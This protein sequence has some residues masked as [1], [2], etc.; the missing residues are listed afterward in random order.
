MH[1][2]ITLVL[3]SCMTQKLLKVDTSYELLILFIKSALLYLFSLTISH[4]CDYNLQFRMFYV[5]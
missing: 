4:F 3:K 2:R 1:L 5:Q